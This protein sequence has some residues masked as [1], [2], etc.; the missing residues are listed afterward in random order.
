M[1]W[2]SEKKPGYCLIWKESGSQFGH[3]PSNLNQLGI[4]TNKALEQ[5]Q[6]VWAKSE[7]KYFGPTYT[8]GVMKNS[9]DKEKHHLEGTGVFYF[10]RQKQDHRLSLTCTVFSM[11]RGRC[12]A[13]LEDLPIYF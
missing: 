5:Q 10:N 7:A 3:L 2:T 12:W 13:C 6:V 8:A 9:Q 4:P 1:S 11:R